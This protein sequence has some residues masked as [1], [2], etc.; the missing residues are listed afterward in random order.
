[1][2][3]PRCSISPVPVT[4]N[5]ARSGYALRHATGDDATACRMLLG[6]LPAHSQPWVAVDGAN[7]LIIGAAALVLA[8]RTKP[9]TGFGCLLH[10]IPPCRASGVGSGLL[11]ALVQRAVQLGGRALYAA[12]R[13]ELDSE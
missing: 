4:F 13:V 5:I 12:R 3:P 10:V 9:L 6:E 7:Q 1:M 11:D 8:P 2:A